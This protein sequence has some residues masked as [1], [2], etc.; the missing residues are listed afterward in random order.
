MSKLS[1]L[2]S[3]RGGHWWPLGTIPAVMLVSQPA[4][5]A[6]TLQASSLSPP[7][8][9]LPPPPAGHR[10]ARTVV[11]PA[12]P[13][14]C[15]VKPLSSLSRLLGPIL[16]SPPCRAQVPRRE[17]SSL[18]TTVPRLGKRQCLSEPQGP[19]LSNGHKTSCILMGLLCRVNE[20]TWHTVSTAEMCVREPH[21]QKRGTQSELD[22][23]RWLQTLNTD[24]A[25]CSG[26]HTLNAC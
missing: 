15:P 23:I 1:S 12:P 25:T 21:A 18:L 26:L 2:W 17:G 4:L 16:L 7:P 24:H 8:A 22:L 11:T 10:L 20:C 3:R 6:P 19:H 13:L 5:P 9:P 14:A